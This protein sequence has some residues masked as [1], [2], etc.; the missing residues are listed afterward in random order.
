MAS[1]TTSISTSI[2]IASRIE[3]CRRQSMHACS[4]REVAGWEAEEDG[5]WDALLN[6]DHTNQYR[7]HPPELFARYAMGL[8]DG[9]VMMRMTTAYRQVAPR[10][11]TGG[12]RIPQRQ[13]RNP[14]ASHIR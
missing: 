7:Q 14:H 8:Q 12:I 4:P 1:T 9:R 13:T 5:L 3:W 10:T 2:S 11:R 6:R